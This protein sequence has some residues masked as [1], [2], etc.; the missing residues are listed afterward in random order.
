MQTHTHTMDVKCARVPVCLLVSADESSMSVHK[1]HMSQTFKSIYSVY[2][3]KTSF[4]FLIKLTKAQCYE[5]QNQSKYMCEK[6]R[7]NVEAKKKK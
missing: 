1:I 5:N 3:G 2:I 7:Q 4:N 6:E